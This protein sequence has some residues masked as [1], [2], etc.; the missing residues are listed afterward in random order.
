MRERS[1]CSL[2]L[3]SA[4]L[5]SPG[6]KSCRKNPAAHIIGISYSAHCKDHACDSLQYCR[7]LACCRQHAPAA[8]KDTA[9]AED[10]REAHK[11]ENGLRLAG[12]QSARDLR[13]EPPQIHGIL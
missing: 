8:I 4:G 7:R 9:G 13:F 6:K 12:A 11:Q 10:R 1:F 2:A 3:R 5:V